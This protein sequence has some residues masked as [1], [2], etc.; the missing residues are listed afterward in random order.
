MRIWDVDP[1]YLARQ[2]LLGEHRELHGLANILIHNKRGYSR[3]P[4]TL[5][6]AGHLPAL[7]MR[8]RQLAC[9]MA[10]R[11]YHDRSPLEAAAE[12]VWPDK[13]IDPPQR[14]FELLHDK[15]ADGRSG[16]IPLPANGQQLWAQHKYSVMARDPEL[17]RQIGPRVARGQDHDGMADLAE[18][19]SGQLRIR[20]QPGC[21]FNALQHMW[22]YV[23]PAGESPSQNSAQLLRRIQQLAA[24][25]QQQ[26]LLQSTALAELG[27]WL[28]EGGFASGQG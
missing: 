19:L 25:Q 14:Q 3:H 27:V 7:A 9:E 6:W 24:E 26:Y 23:A 10:L 18:L 11:G 15:Y 4:E 13:W 17:Y 2:Q 16:R 8:H 1:G 5:R 21:L 28:E 20:P 12:I 22:G